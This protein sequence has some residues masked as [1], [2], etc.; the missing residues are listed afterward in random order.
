[1]VAGQNPSPHEARERTWAS[2]VITTL[3]A[4]EVHKDEDTTA[5]TVAEV[6]GGEVCFLGTVGADPGLPLSF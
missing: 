1:V 2:E 4:R 5:I 6:A 3:V